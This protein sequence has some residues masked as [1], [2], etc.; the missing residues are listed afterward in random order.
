MKKIGKKII[1][2]SLQFNLYKLV[3]YSLP[4][5]L[6]DSLRSENNWKESLLLS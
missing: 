4:Q 3:F 5:Y 6:T 1:F 2:Q